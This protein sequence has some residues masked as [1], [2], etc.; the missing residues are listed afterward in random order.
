MQIFFRILVVCFFAGAPFNSLDAAEN[1]FLI[2][3]RVYDKGSEAAAVKLLLPIAK[4]GD[5]RAQHL[6]GYIYDMTDGTAGVK[7][8]DTKALFWY[9]KAV[10]QDYTPALRNLAFHLIREFKNV[11]RGIRL[12]K[13]AAERGDAEAQYGMG[14]YLWAPN[15]WGTQVDRPAARKW[16]LKAIEQKFARAATQLLLLYS[17]DGDYIEA[18]KWDVIGQYLSEQQGSR[19]KGPLILPDIRR[20]MTKSQ[21]AEAKRRAVAWL[22]ARR[23]K[24]I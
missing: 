16:L 5:P 21:I 2:A 4:A 22:V 11:K 13:I 8:D 23:E 10:Q 3:R 1:D 20:K 14:Y 17:A 24:P 9:E 19:V 12:L 6:L 18:Y 15:T 7:G